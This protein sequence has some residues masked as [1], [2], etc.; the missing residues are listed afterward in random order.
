MALV[1]TFALTLVSFG[2]RPL[3][4]EVQTA[5][6][7]W[8]G[9]DLSAICADGGD[10]H[11]AADICAAC[12]IAQTAMLPDPASACQTADLAKGP[13]WPDTATGRLTSGRP[14]DHPA[15]APPARDHISYI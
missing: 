11:A 3:Q 7:L 10:P 9:G 5:A 4:A 6:Y 14:A 2:H 13:A 1:L 15:R 8:A 12:I